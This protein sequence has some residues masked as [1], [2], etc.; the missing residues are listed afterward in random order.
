MNVF[1][2]EPMSEEEKR[3][4]AAAAGRA[5][6]M[7]AGE[8]ARAASAA[9]TAAGR[10]PVTSSGLPKWLLPVGLVVVGGVLFFRGGSK[11]AKSRG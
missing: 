1:V 4:R 9:A 8:A 7:A 6:G 2:G 5:Q 11:N 3:G 10:A